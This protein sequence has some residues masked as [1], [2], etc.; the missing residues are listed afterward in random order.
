MKNLILAF[1]F[2]LALVG[3]AQA[4]TCT[5]TVNVTTASTN[6]VAAS[7]V[8]GGRHY[9]LLQNIGAVD[10]QCTIGETATT[11]K[12]FILSAVG[13]GSI[14]FSSAQGPNGVFISVPNQAVNCITGSSTSNVSI[15]DY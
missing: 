13:H 4:D 2:T 3:Y 1:I 14:L 5:G 15:C 11:S 8:S 6:I 10:V 12:G 9:L 7:D